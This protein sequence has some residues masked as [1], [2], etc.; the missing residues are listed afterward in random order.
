MKAKDLTKHEVYESSLYHFL[1]Q[2]TGNT[3]ERNDWGE[4]T[5]LYE[6]RIISFKKHD[7][8]FD[9]LKNMKFYKSASGLKYFQPYNY[10]TN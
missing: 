5:K 4:I 1:L 10:K 2:Y 8:V 7:P 9:S 6:F 3:T